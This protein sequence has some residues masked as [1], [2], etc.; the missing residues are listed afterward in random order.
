MHV[1]LIRPGKLYRYSEERWL[2]RA[3]QHGEFRLRPASDYFLAESIG[4]R[5]DNELVRVHTSPG[6]QVKVFMDGHTEPFTPLGDVTYTSTAGTDYMLLC[7]SSRWD[8]HL[9]DDFIPSDSCLII[10][11]VNEFAERLHGA[12]QEQLPGWVGMEWMLLSC[13]AGKVHWV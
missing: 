4:A 10:H 1:D 11:E 5:H 12:V 2:V 9:F 7:F 8:E 6:A 13:M 3:L